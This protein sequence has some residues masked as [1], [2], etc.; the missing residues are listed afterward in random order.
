MQLTRGELSPLDAFVSGKVRVL[1]S[2]GLAQVM[3]ARL[4]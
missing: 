3:V 4:Q 1:G 2:I